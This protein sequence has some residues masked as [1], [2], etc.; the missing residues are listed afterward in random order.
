MKLHVCVCLSRYYFRTYAANVEIRGVK[1]LG[2]WPY[3]TDGV[4][5]GPNGLVTD[6][7]IRSND[8]SIKLFSCGFTPSLDRVA[9][10]SDLVHRANR[11][12][13]KRARSAATMSLIN[14]A[15]LSFVAGAG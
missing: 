3:N 15:D 5:T 7:F 12:R 8:D 13:T 9:W 11:I 2:C 10:T 6:T 1:L 14:S 4:V